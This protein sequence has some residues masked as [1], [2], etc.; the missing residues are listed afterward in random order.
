M[1]SLLCRISKR[2]SL[3]LVH[4]HKMADKFTGL[5]GTGLKTFVLPASVMLASQT[6]GIAWPPLETTVNPAGRHRRYCRV[7]HMSNLMFDK[8]LDLVLET[9]EELRLRGAE[10]SMLL[11]GPCFGKDEF[12]RVSEFCDQYSDSTEYLGPVYGKDK[13]T[14]FR[15]IDVFLFP[16][17]YVN[18]SWGIVL[19]EAK[20]YGVP[21]VAIDQGCVAAAVGNVGGLVLKRDLCFA[22]LAADQIEAW[23]EDG[24]EKTQADVL[25]ESV[26]ESRDNQER[27]RALLIELREMLDVR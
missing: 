7:G 20:T 15:N 2:E 22:Q 26:I 27:L 10:T 14:F 24:W 12:L 16:S 5:Y 1:I 21:I 6:S 13:E 3:H 19:S 18:E 25:E 4:C 11:A 17:T 23:M 9:F 8:G